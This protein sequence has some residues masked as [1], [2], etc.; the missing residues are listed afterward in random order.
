MGTAM[1]QEMVIPPAM[2]CENCGA[3][4]REEA[5][6]RVSETE[7]AVRYACSECRRQKTR[8][9]QSAPT[10]LDEG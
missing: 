7:V 6:E 4:A 8:R 5:R 10:E 3:L 2:R 1:H 9:F